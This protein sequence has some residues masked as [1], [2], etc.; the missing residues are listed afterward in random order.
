MDPDNTI[1]TVILRSEL[2]RKLTGP[3]YLM[4]KN[5]TDEVR[6]AMQHAISWMPKSEPQESPKETRRDLP[7]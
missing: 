1:I 7:A 3:W 2:A 5:E 6:A 4:K